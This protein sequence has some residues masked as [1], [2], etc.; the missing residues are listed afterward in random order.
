M[1]QLLYQIL[2]IWGLSILNDFF[3]E[4]SNSFK[5]VLHVIT[6]I[7]GIIIIMEYVIEIIFDI[8]YYYNLL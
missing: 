7:Y 1:Y 4:E 6:Y 2:I 3:L 5:M 8:V